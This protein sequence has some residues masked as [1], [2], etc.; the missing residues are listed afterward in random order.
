MI[1]I[2]NPSVRKLD[3]TF[4]KENFADKTILHYTGGMFGIGCRLS[5]MD[6]IQRILKQKQRSDNKGLIV[7]LPHIDWFKVHSIYIPERLHPLLEQ[8]WPG[9]LTVVFKCGDP[10]FEHV[11]VDG[12]VAFRVPHDALLRYF[13]EQLDEPMIST[14][15][16]IA[17]LPPESDLKRI[18]GIFGDWFDY[19]VIPSPD[20]YDKEWQ[21]STIVEYVDSHE[22]KNQSGLDELK[23][24]REKAIP[25]Y[26][27]KKAFEKPTILF[28]CTANI[29]RSP[30]AEK[31]FNHYVLQEELSYAGDSC[32]LIEGGHPISESSKQLL[33][34]MGIE[35]ARDHVSKQVTAQMVNGCRLILTMEERQRD[36]MIKQQPEAARKIFTLNEIVGETGDIAD[37]Y[38]SEFNNYRKTFAMIEDR[39]KRLIEKIKKR[40]LTFSN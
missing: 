33:L 26:E 40:E 21:A 27:V 7:L 6:A 23:C 28:V 4:R 19:G 38:G 30:I 39:I 32:G 29:C 20:I 35:E 14:S 16:N 11:E 10:R 12:K 9:N 31:L 37:P 17:S 25:F 8:Y 2:K 22:E 3:R 1:L 36:Y 15:I 24:L 13:L 5:S 34:D 18:I